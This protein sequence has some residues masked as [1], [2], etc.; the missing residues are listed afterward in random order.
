M[1]RP[2]RPDK[3]IAGDFIL[4]FN[5][6]QVTA[7]FHL[8]DVIDIAKFSFLLH[9][10]IQR[11]FCKASETPGACDEY[12]NLWLTLKRMISLSSIRTLLNLP[13]THA[14]Q[15]FSVSQYLV[16][17]V[18]GR[19]RTVDFRSAFPRLNRYRKDLSTS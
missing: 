13:D 4:Q 18:F 12:T 14:G 9:H 3:C 7:G 16:V 2:Q 1:I 6:K 10:C 19:S 11:K 8:R 5:K 17:S 15:S